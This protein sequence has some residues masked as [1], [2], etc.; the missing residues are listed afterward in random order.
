[1]SVLKRPM[2]TFLRV[3]I[4]WINSVQVFKLFGRSSNWTSEPSEVHR[5]LATF[6]LLW[7]WTQSAFSGSW[8]WKY[9]PGLQN[10][11]KSWLCLLDLFHH[12]KGKFSA[13]ELAIRKLNKSYLDTNLG[14]R[15]SNLPEM[16]C[17]WPPMEVKQ[18]TL[19]LID[20]LMKGEC[21]CYNN[22]LVVYQMV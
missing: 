7:N 15:R 9:L 17:Y 8:Y 2:S 14:L 10:P 13:N 21:L 20:M 12:Y 1:M 3:R 16:S 5:W 4:V 11:E 18:A 22:E 19:N 6:L